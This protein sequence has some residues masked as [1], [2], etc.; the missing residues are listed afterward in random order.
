MKLFPP[1]VGIDISN[2]SGAF[3]IYR[4]ELIENLNREFIPPCRWPRE[5]PDSTETGDRFFLSRDRRR[6]NTLTSGLHFCCRQEKM[7]CFCF[8]YPFQGYPPRVAP[9]CF[10]LFFFPQEFQATFSL[11]VHLKNCRIHSPSFSPNQ[12]SPWCV[13]W[14][15]GLSSQDDFRLEL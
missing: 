6:G 13:L 11:L 15:R 14:L 1:S 8:G 10:A 12:P 9:P 4:C 7:T 5:S 3:C 2:E